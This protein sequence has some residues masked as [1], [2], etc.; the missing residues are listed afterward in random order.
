M[1][2]RVDASVD[3]LL[4][5]LARHSA[6]ATFFT[7]GW[8]A[9]RKPELVKRIVAAGH[10]VASHSWWHRRV[11]TLDA[12]PISRRR[13]PVSRGAREPDRAAGHR[14]SR[15]QLLHRSGYRMGLRRAHR[16]GL[17]LR[18]ERV[19]HPPTRLRL[20][21]G[22]GVSHMRS[23]APQACCSSS[24]WQPRSQP[25][26]AFRRRAAAGCGMRVLRRWSRWWRCL[27]RLFCC[28]RRPAGQ[29]VVGGLR[30]RHRARQQQNSFGFKMEER[31]SKESLRN[32][33]SPPHSSCGSSSSSY[34]AHRSISV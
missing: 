29:R 17:S 27:G 19:S 32:L 28:R 5:L 21:G 2:S 20:C 11:A 16:G 9:E 30:L 23:A 24:R 33:F 18:F 14:V 15:P 34:W 10:E 22:P 12:G 31:E 13:A 8:L 4:E 6:T 26:C 1:P 7:V 25:A 3:R